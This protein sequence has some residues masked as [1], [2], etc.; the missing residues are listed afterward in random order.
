MHTITFEAPITGEYKIDSIVDQ[1]NSGAAGGRGTGP[2]KPGTGLP[3]WDEPE[4]TILV[5]FNLY[6][7]DDGYTTAIASSTSGGT[8]A[9]SWTDFVITDTVSLVA[10]DSYQLKFGYVQ[11][12]DSDDTA[13]ASFDISWNVYTIDTIA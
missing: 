3:Y 2:I 12:T 6:G 11:I 4:D 9:F 1:N 13:T 7:P 8:G 5:F 10:G